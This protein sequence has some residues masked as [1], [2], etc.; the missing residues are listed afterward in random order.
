MMHWFRLVT[1]TGHVVR[2]TV[3]EGTWTVR[4]S[5]GHGVREGREKRLTEQMIRTCD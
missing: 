5:T 1:A 3:R 4:D 2:V